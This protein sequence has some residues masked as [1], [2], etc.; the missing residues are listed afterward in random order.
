MA[1]RVRVAASACLVASGLFIGGAGSAIAL[2]E[3]GHSYSHSD[4]HSDDAKGEDAIGG[5][6]ND[7]SGTDAGH[8]RKPSESR[9]N[10]QTRWGNGRP[11]DG[12]SGE[13]KPE[14]KPG[15]PKP[16]DP[17]PGDPKPGDPKPGGS[18]NPKD[19]GNPKDPKDPCGGD[20]D[21]PGGD[22]GDP[23]NPGG[24]PDDPGGDPGDPGGPPP[25]QPP[26]N[27]PQSSGGGGGGGA[28]VQF[29]TYTP[30]HVPGMQL[31]DELQ[32]Q[33][34]VLD[35]G[36]GAAAAAPLGPTAPI[37]LPVIV[38]PPIGLGAGAGGSGAGGASAGPP[39][40]APRAVTAEPPAGR[41]P[42]AAAGANR[43]GPN[44]SYRIGYT[45]YLRS[46]GLPQVAALAL[47]GLAGILVLT[48]AGGFVGYR[49]AKA[50]HAVRVGGSARYMR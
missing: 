7:S 24:D 43:M 25:G 47:P 35:A 10:P 13:E 31:P 14:P 34:G 8:A 50:G 45:E 27:P 40:V 38:A 44:S 33:P 5:S 22:P 29:P 4:G 20:P 32:P 19:P 12:Q 39:P 9:G 11:R 23:G 17:R 41:I 16:G 26:P 46:A 36:A 37:V 21:D 28:V 48:G 2:A 15:D 18:D 30:P 6:L 1:P 49:Q 3:P 42:P